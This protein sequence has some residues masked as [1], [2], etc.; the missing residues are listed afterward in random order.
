VGGDGREGNS[1]AKAKKPNR[2]TVAP[3]RIEKKKKKKESAKGAVGGKWKGWATIGSYKKKNTRGVS[4]AGGISNGI[5]RR[6]KNQRGFDN[7]TGGRGGV[8]S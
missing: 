3:V 2:H 7:T 8:W 5:A 6:K 1:I 4:S